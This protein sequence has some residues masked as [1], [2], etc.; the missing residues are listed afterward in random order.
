MELRPPLPGS[1]GSDV[2]HY[3]ATVGRNPGPSGSPRAFS[4]N[5]LEIS[6]PSH[7]L[8]QFTRSIA[9]PLSTYVAPCRILDTLR[10]PG[11][12]SEWETPNTIHVV[13]TTTLT[14]PHFCPHLT[15]EQTKGQ[16]GMSCPGVPPYPGPDGSLLQFS[17]HEPC[18][19]AW[20]PPWEGPSRHRGSAAPSSLSHAGQAEGQFDPP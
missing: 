14:W 11:L 2:T 4:R 6:G 18:G 9:T 3:G 20:Q 19:P 15:G 5:P 16:G 17:E 8:A 12:V 1:K 13:P 7:V 10:I